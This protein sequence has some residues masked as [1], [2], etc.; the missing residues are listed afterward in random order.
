M[1]PIAAWLR[2][3]RAQQTDPRTGKRGW[4]QAYTA[5]RITAETDRALYREQLNAYEN[6]RGMQQA[7]YDWFVDFWAQH[8]VTGAPEINAKAEPVLSLEERAV[9]AAERQAQALEDQVEATKANTLML[10]RVLAALMGRPRP[11]DDDPTEEDADEA[12]AE[13]LAGE[14]SS[15]SRRPTHHPRPAADEPERRTRESAA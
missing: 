2:A 4:S 3:A 13:L 11:E 10:S 14:G 5:E 12:I 6:G 1:T 7:T 9:L 8:G 15:M